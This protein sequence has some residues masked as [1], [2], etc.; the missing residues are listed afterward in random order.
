M[1]TVR[2]VLFVMCDQR[3]RNFV[4]FHEAARIALR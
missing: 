2:N 3:R 1:T 4:S